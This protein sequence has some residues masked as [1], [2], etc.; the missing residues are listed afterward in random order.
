[1]NKNIRDQ[2]FTISAWK[3]FWQ[4][5]LL[6]VAYVTASFRREKRSA[7]L[8][9]LTVTIVVAFTCTLQAMVDSSPVVFL[10]LSEETAGEIDVQLS[11]EGGRAGTPFVNFT[12]VNQL[13]A[14]NPNVQGAAPRW[15]ALGKL[16]PRDS[17]LST[18]VTLLIMNSALEDAANIGR[19][20]DRRALGENEIYAVSILAV[21]W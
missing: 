15:I 5:L 17:E 14:Q 12:E 21:S 8:G 9:I 20:W 2:R 16:Q 13:I 18:G 7:I 11:A 3:Y 19:K 4:S 1:M 10:R 6:A